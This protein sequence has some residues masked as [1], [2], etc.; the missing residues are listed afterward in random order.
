MSVLKDLCE[1]R[2]VSG[3]EFQISEKIKAEF[4]KYC[5]SVLIDSL[6]NVIGVMGK[7]GKKRIMVEAHYDEIGL[8]VKDID[9]NG[10]VRFDQIGG[11]N[12]SVL[13]SAGV[14]IHGAEEVCGV[15][16]AKPPHLQDEE[17]N[18]KPYA[19]DKLYIDTGFDRAQLSEKISIGDPISFEASSKMLLNNIFTSKAIDNRM[20][21]Y[22]LIA[23][24]KRLK[25]RL[26]DVEMTFLAAVQEEVGCRGAKVGAY[27]IDPDCAIVIDVTHG[28]SPYT[29]S[30]DITF[31]LGSG[32]P[33]AVG[34]N[35]HP[36]LTGK[37]IG[38]AKEKGIPYT[39]EV[40]GGSSGTDAWVIQVAKSGIPSAVLSAPLRYMHTQV[41]TVCLD[42][43][44]AIVD[45]ICT[46]T[47]EG[48]V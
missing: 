37:L 14:I 4:E 9:D 42:D 8:I 39:V 15:V 21:I 27:R 30:T 7:G 26:D 11:V 34:P 44:D 16:G 29:G 31:A 47:E 38:T 3:F 22:C 28:T 45:L 41:E 24:M 10:F 6:G 13:P 23:C 33:V 46:A 18:K 19:F 48:L 36:R 40:S 2:G 35:L 20:G 43:V 32:V 25:G 12:K 17:E 5:D 1:M